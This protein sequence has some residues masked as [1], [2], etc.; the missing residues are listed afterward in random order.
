M[1]SSSAVVC[2][3]CETGISEKDRSLPASAP[4]SDLRPQESDL[5]P[6]E[7]WVCPSSNAEGERCQTEQEGRVFSSQ[8]LNLCD[9]SERAEGEAEGENVTV[10]ILAAEGCGKQAEETDRGEAV[11]RDEQEAKKG[12]EQE[13]GDGAAKRREEETSTESTLLIT[14]SED[15]KTSVMGLYP[16]SGS[17]EV[18]NTSD[19]EMKGEDVE[20]EELNQGFFDGLDD[21]EVEK[22]G[23]TDPGTTLEDVSNPSLIDCDDVIEE[24]ESSVPCL[25]I[26]GLCEGEP[27][28]DINSP[29]QNQET[30]GRDYVAE[31]Q[32][33]LASEAA[34]H[35]G[36]CA[37]AV[38][39]K[40]LDG[41]DLPDPLH[42]QSRGS[43]LHEHQDLDFRTNGSATK[44][45][46]D[47]LNS[48][49][50]HEEMVTERK[51][52][53]ELSMAHGFSSDEDSFISFR[54]SSTEIFNPTQDNGTVDDGDLLRTNIEEPFLDEHRTENPKSL[55]SAESNKL[56]LGVDGGLLLEPGPVSE[57]TPSDCSKDGTDPESQLS[58]SCKTV[59][60][61]RPEAIKEQAPELPEDLSILS[62]FSTNK[63]ILTED[64]GYTGKS[65]SSALII[66]IE[67][68][69]S[70]LSTEV[71]TKSGL[72]A[73]EGWNVTGLF[74]DDQQ[75]DPSDESEKGG[76]EQFVFEQ[77]KLEDSERTSKEDSAENHLCVPLSQDSSITNVSSLEVEP[78]VL[79]T[80]ASA[81]HHTED[82]VEEDLKTGDAVDGSLESCSSVDY[83]G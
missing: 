54:N 61:V 50:S 6:P 74:K 29:E 1:E 70:E 73:T 59:E 76:N 65:N 18:S 19:L 34:C 20:N 64:K 23:L 81:D 42:I 28:P 83:G 25:L 77:P 48:A 30:A 53:Y 43:P 44:T 17:S 35:S 40:E 11:I 57:L 79:E 36:N 56:S 49:L 14:T 58:S 7:D 4:T 37:E 13:A 62:V 39:S 51:T 75:I 52:D 68:S 31:Q 67:T 10:G 80:D 60:A 22:D 45:Q 69:S 2:E 47:L 66:G 78:P 26:E 82:Q 63:D 21:E 27:P 38:S 16:S 71:L 15:T 5:G 12:E 72:T 32:W 46:N 3:L 9:K 41:E 8:S 33:S 24:Y 55:K